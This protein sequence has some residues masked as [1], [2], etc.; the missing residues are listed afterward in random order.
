[1]LLNINMKNIEIRTL[2]ENEIKYAVSI[3]LKASTEAHHFIAPDFWKSK[4]SEM[5]SVWLPAAQNI[6][7]FINGKMIGFFSLMDERLAAIFI[8]PEEQNKGY[9]KL[10]M[11]HA[12]SLKLQLTLS[13]YEKNKSALEFYRKNNFTIFDKQIDEATGENEIIMAWKRS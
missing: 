6:G 11:N 4:V 12:K 3:W 7:L 5:E 1:M 2:Q 8:L 13:V 10:L 9:G